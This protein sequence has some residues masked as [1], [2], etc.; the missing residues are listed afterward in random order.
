TTG[1]TG[2][3]GAT[4]CR[5]TSVSWR[6][7]GGTPDEVFHVSEAAIAC[8]RQSE[9]RRA[10]RWWKAGAEYGQRHEVNRTR[11]VARGRDAR[12]FAARVAAAIALALLIA[13]AEAPA[14]ADPPAATAPSTDL[15]DGNFEQWKD[16]MPVAWGIRN[17]ATT[18]SGA[19]SIV[20][21]GREGGIAL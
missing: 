6:R 16:G 20:E 14:R 10:H 12:R 13:H 5:N 15:V 19:A 3:L 8:G 11:T 1:T 18:G 4:C 9:S 17:G 2:R 7:S 21:R